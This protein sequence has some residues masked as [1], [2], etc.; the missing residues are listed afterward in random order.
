MIFFCLEI[1]F[2]GALQNGNIFDKVGITAEI[3]WFPEI[4]VE[5]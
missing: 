5:S 3:H 2:F 1:F 4:L